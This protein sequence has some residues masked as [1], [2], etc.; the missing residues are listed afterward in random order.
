[1]KGHCLHWDTSGR[2]ASRATVLIV[3]LDDN[4]VLGNT[5]E[6]VTGVC[7]TRNR[8]SSARNSLDAKTVLAVDDLVVSEVDVADSVVRAAANRADR[9]TVATSARAAREG[10]VS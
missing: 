10:D 3:L 2:G 9:K 7:D 6:G 1:M 4:T 5:G 8:A